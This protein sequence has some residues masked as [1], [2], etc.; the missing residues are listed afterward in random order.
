MI[1]ELML[2][3]LLV[4]WITG[5]KFTR[6]ADAR[7]KLGWM[8]FLPVALYLVCWLPPLVKLHWFAG[9]MNL[10]ERLALIT[11]GIA[12]WRLPGVKLIVLGLVMNAVA[13][14]ANGGFM[15]ANAGAIAAAFGD[16]YLK[17]AMTATH[18]RSAIMDTSTELGF[19]CD[20][21][22][23]KRPLVYVPA[24]Y[25][26]GDLVMSTGIFITIIAL[27]RTPLPSEKARA[28]EEPVGASS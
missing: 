26:V 22:A 28:Q 16:E 5:G 14:A 17:S 24:V 11:V 2:I 21:I 15:P 7:I 6:L 4:G 27:M 1:P 19:L 3:A 12:N 18:V 9:A 13:I 20:I 10:I 8:I 23:A 25:S